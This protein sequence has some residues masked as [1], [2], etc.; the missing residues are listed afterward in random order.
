[1]TSPT[2][3]LLTSHKRAEAGRRLL[4]GV[5]HAAPAAS[6]GSVCGFAG[7]VARQGLVQV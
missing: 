6:G 7:C 3:G 5:W 2:C 4:L 1:M